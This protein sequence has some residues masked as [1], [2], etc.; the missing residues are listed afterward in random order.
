MRIVMLLAVLAIIGMILV[1]WL[2]HKPPAAVVT[3]ETANTVT[4]P[5]VPTRPEDLKKFEK[6]IN[7]FMQD[8][9]RQ[10]LEKAP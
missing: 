7:R 9:A 2:G 5:P 6:D 1:Q 8:S 3:S 4:P 10:H